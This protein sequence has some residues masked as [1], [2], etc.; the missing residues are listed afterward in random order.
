MKCN[1]QS[2]WLCRAALI[3]ASHE[4]TEWIG[5]HSIGEFGY[6]PQACTKYHQMPPKPDL[7]RSTLDLERGAGQVSWQHF[8]GT[9]KTMCS[10]FFFC[11]RA[12]V[13]PHHVQVC[14]K[15]LVSGFCTFRCFSSC[16]FSGKLGWKDANL[17][18]WN[19][20]EPGLATSFMGTCATI[21][22]RSLKRSL[23]PGHHAA[24]N[25]INA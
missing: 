17:L 6:L 7:M 4:F 3:S 16:V 1:Q 21:R 12:L 5:T 2:K 8:E 14:F 24:F 25:H 22:H 20:E 10:L 18:K 19:V 13:L 23:K 11:M 15:W 9:F